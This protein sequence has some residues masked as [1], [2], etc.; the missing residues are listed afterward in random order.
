MKF[1]RKGTSNEPIVVGRKFLGDS[2]GDR[3]QSCD[4][5]F[6]NQFSI[7]LNELRVRRTSKSDERRGEERRDDA[8]LG[9]FG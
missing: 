7:V 3:R 6:Q 2:V 1:D 9:I 8:L 4:D 5:L